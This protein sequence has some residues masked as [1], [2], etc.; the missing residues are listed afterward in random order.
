MN[1]IERDYYTDM[2]VLLD[3]YGWFEEMR[4]KGPVCRM[5]NRDLWLVTGF[6]AAVEILNNANDW[7][8]AISVSGPLLP[9]PFAV[10][11]DDITDLLVEHRPEIPMS[12]LLVA[13]DGAS[14]AQSR[15]LIAALFTPSRLRENQTYVTELADKMA[16]AVVAN[17]S[18]E[19][20]SEIASP[21][22]TYVVSD[23]LGVPEEDRD[24]FRKIIDAAPPPGS[25]E[26]A[27]PPGKEIEWAAKSAEL[28]AES[29]SN[30]PLVFMAQFFYLY[31]AERR[32]TQ[33]Q[34]DVL[35]E[36]A[37]ASFPD[38]TQPD[39]P[40]LIRLATFLFG[41]GQ[42]TSA[43]L[44]GNAMRYLVDIPGMQ[45]QLRENPALIPDFLEEVLRLEGSTKAVKRLAKRP[46]MV[47]GHQIAAGDKVV[48][49]ISAANRDPRRWE[50]PLEFRLK[51]PGIKQHLAFGRGAHTCAGAPLA[52]YEVRIMFEK[53]LEHTRNIWLV[54][55]AHGPAGERRWDWEATFS[56]RGLNNLYVGF[57][58][59]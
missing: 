29:S 20:I 32:A 45:T 55:E 54:E 17:R 34:D 58:P 6:E 38:G 43:K 27:P 30:S 35:S 18:C 52:R 11:G 12:D 1:A 7:S 23:I 49:A 28:Q 25:M 22:V 16:R 13:K 31:I 19:L 10:E 15:S 26:A 4:A 47:G 40:E 48:I 51:R 5:A 42:D 57:D 41:A 8:N 46:M 56:M 37:H 53:L 44:I 24:E 39:I 21:F 2:S 14:H 9:L 36:F 33:R 50:D 59:A 3:P